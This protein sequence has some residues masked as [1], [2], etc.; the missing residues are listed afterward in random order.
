MNNIQY[1]KSIKIIES[2]IIQDS[3]MDKDSKEFKLLNLL[4]E[5][6]EEYEKE[7]FIIDKFNEEWYI[8]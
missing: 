5:L 2:Y 1:E 8:I 6:T 3:Y 7:H 4:L